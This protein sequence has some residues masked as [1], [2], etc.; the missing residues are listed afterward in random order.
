M[1]GPRI[2]AIDDGSA[3]QTNIKRRT[4]FAPF[5]QRGA[6]ASQN[7][8]HCGVGYGIFL[9]DQLIKVFKVI[10]GHG[11][12]TNLV[13]PLKDASKKYQ[14]ALSL[15]APSESSIHL[16]LPIATILWHTSR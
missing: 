9:F 13:S 5:V 2:K 14:Q 15:P 12:P 3:S 8:R 6:A 7:L 10:S 4:C 16:T 1:F 11:R